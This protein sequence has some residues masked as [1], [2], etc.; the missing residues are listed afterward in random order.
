MPLYGT[1]KLCLR[2]STIV[3]DSTIEPFLVGSGIFKTQTCSQETKA[4]TSFKEDKSRFFSH[5]SLPT[6]E[7]ILMENVQDKQ[8]GVL[9]YQV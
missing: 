7:N 1:Y 8:K 2:I 5:F 6:I 3:I 9:N 4:T